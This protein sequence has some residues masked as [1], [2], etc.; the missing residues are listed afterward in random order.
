MK[1]S[2]F[3]GNGEGSKRVALGI[4]VKQNQGVKNQELR[5]GIVRFEV[6]E[7]RVETPNRQVDICLKVS[8]DHGC[9]SF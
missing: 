3:L 1:R 9:A 8:R 2:A 4:K 5:N 7:L 6:T